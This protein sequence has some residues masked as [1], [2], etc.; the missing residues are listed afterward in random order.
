M[1][2]L[3]ISTESFAA[4]AE[5]A[6]VS[7][8]SD[9]PARRRRPWRQF[10]L[11]AF[12]LA[13]TFVSIVL[14]W[15]GIQ[16]EHARRQRSALEAMKCVEEAHYSYEIKKLNPGWW[17]D[18]DTTARSPVPNFVKSICGDNIFSDVV[19]AEAGNGR[20]GRAEVVYLG[21]LRTLQW[22]RLGWY[23][24]S[25][26]GAIT[27]LDLADSDLAYIRGLSRLRGLSIRSAAITDAGW[28][29]LPV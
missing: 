21:N 9:K 19:S 6:A 20:A 27:D 4:V 11:R 10:S 2:Q 17:P 13:L 24:G 28:R 25:R 5:T 15:L 22:L 12:L 18:W 14:G 16:I 7:Q 23:N 29:T 3:S 1:S 8:H 26:Q